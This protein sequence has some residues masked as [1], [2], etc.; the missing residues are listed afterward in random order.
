MKE[1]EEESLNEEDK[2]VWSQFLLDQNLLFYKCWKSL[3]VAMVIIS[4]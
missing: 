1:T 4:F 3:K 2:E